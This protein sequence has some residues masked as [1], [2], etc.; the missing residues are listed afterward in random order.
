MSPVFYYEQA[1]NLTVKHFD[2]FEVVAHNP[3]CS[4]HPILRL[5]T[6]TECKL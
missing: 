4:L 1:Q 5:F 6:I 3:V 2:V